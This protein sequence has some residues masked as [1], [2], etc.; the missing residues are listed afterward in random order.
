MSRL[1]LGFNDDGFALSVAFV[2]LQTFRTGIGRRIWKNRSRFSFQVSTKLPIFETNVAG[3]DGLQ[4][5]FYE[6]LNKRDY[7]KKPQF[8]KTLKRYRKIRQQRSRT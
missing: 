3:D 5:N 2:R 7:H 1:R 4:I 6:L 8:K